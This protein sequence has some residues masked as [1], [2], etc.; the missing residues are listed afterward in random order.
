M[1]E[2]MYSLI[3]TFGYFGI[4]LVNLIATASIFI[5]I[6]GWLFTVPAGFY[7]NPVLVAIAAGTGAAIGE[8]T[9]YGIGY[10]GKRI[11]LSRQKG[12]KKKYTQKWL[13]KIEFWFK[14]HGGF[15]VIFLFALTPLPDDF[16]GIFCGAVKYD[17]KKF[18]L[19][20]LIGKIMMSLLLV[21][22]GL[23]GLSW[24]LGL[25]GVGL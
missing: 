5:P 4:F 1:F 14:K 23:Y 16:V 7:L 2:F 3:L 20:Q 17:I 19:A 24:F 21:Y 12:K 18:F 9:S 10:A 22:A 8:L 25:F 11:Y 6:P 13:E 15:V